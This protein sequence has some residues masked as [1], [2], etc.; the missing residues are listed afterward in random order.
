M[1]IKQC[2]WH[3]PSSLASRFGAIFD[4]RARPDAETRNKLEDTKLILRVN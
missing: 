2:E 4:I 1:N 3:L